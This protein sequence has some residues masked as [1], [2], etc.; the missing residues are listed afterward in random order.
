MGL[1][2]KEA[3]VEGHAPERMAMT[4]ERGTR[5]LLALFVGVLAVW[6][7]AGKVRDHYLL[8]QVWPTLPPNEQ[9]LTVVGTLDSRS[10]YDRNMFIIVQ[11]NKTSRVA[12]TTYGWQSIFTGTDGPMFTDTVGEAIKAAIGVDSL[13]GHAMLEPFL[14]VGV[15][16]VLQKP[17]NEPG[18]S[19]QTPIV[20]R[21]TSSATVK[22]TKATL[23]DL[24]KR[25]EDQGG[26]DRDGESSVPGGGSASGK[27]VEE[28]LTIPGE[29]LVRACPVVLTGAHFTGASLERH[30]PNLLTGETF[31]VSLSLTPEGRSRFYQWSR[32][33]ANESLVFVLKGRV[34]TAGR[35]RDTLDVNSWEI[36]NLRDGQ[37][38]HE[39]V[40]FVNKGGPA[41]ASK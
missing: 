28:K 6:F 22:E 17:M 11:S 7:L 3:E 8:S 20:V 40:D 18:I 36:T 37:V 27:E 5:R 14:R 32:N 25:Y 29:N 16:R 24:L 10:S 33:H 4:R 1:F 12:L 9:G 38:A 31:T 26:R 21:D 23:G 15:H 30:P 39:L 19:E 34:L 2:P 13:T 35:I 41:L